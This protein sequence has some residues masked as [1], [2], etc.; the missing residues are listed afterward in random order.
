MILYTDQLAAKVAK[1]LPKEALLP[2]FVPNVSNRMD[3]TR[4][5][6]LP[7]H[8]VLLGDSGAFSRV[9]AWQWC[10]VIIETTVN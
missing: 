9:L 4:P 2:T 10:F 3:A 7:V 1:N 6:A 8:L 5:T